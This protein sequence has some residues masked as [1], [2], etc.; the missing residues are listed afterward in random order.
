MQGTQFITTDLY[1][2][3]NSTG[4]GRGGS[5]LQ[6]SHMIMNGKRLGSKSEE[7]HLSVYKFYITLPSH[8]IVHTRRVE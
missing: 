3:S 5:C 8:K 1:E 6:F 2:I 4:D 7:E